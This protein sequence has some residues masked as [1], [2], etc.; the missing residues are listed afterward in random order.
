[1]AF[2][3]SEIADHLQVLE[4]KFWSLRRPALHLRQKLREGQRFTDQAIELFLVRPAYNRPGE[5]FEE[6][7][8][9]IRF[10]RT[11]KVW[12]LYW[13]RADGKWHGY[14]PHP[15]TRSLA[16]ALAIILNDPHGCFFG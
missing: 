3:E 13:K 15:Q 2:T 8:A 11:T 12:R 9:K 14:P 1:M 4:D 5:Q 7:L 16:D 10:V 6:S